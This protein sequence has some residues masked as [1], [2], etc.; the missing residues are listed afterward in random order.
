MRSKLVATV[1]TASLALGLAIVPAQWASAASSIS[2]GVY[3]C[4]S[5]IQRVQLSSHASGT[6]NHKEGVTVTGVFTNGNVTK[7]NNSN[8]RKRS[9]P[10]WQVYLT[11]VG[12]NVIS[13]APFCQ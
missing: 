8:T 6:V 5:Q 10:N 11:G 12:G 3:S 7:Y 9:I 2:G 4:A 13:A 1:A